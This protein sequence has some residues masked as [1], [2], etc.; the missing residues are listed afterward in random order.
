[1]GREELKP[2]TLTF[3]IAGDTSR[4]SYTGVQKAATATGAQ[5]TVYGPLAQAIQ[6]MLDQQAARIAEL[7]GETYEL[8]YAAAGGEDAPRAANAVTVADVERWRRENEATM[9]EALGRAEKAEAERDA[10]IRAL[11]KEGR[12]RG[13]AEARADAAWVAGRDAAAD[14]AYAA[15]PKEGPLMI[16]TQGFVDAIRALTPPGTQP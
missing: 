10:A 5:Y 11:S 2:A 7:E 8:K 9:R 6:A 13:E 3:D 12:L 4:S 14:A 15:G 16:V 1:M